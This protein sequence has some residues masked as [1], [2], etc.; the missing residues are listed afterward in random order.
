MKIISTLSNLRVT[1][2]CVVT[3]VAAPSFASW[4]T[5]SAQQ[6]GGSRAL[7]RRGLTVDGRIE[8]AVQQL[9]S[10]DATI[11]DGAAITG[12]LLAPGIPAVRQ[13]QSANLGSITQGSG[14]EQ[15]D[16]YFVTLS[17]N[18]QLG[19][20]KRRTDPVTIPI[21]AAPPGAN[22]S[23]DVT[24]SESDHDAG[25]FATIRDLTITGGGVIA[26]PPGTYRDL[27]ATGGGGFVLGTAG[28]TQPA[29]YNI[30]SLALNE[31]GQLQIVGPV[32]LTMAASVNL[33][34]S[35]GASGNPHWLSL[36]VASGDVTL[37]GGGSLFGLVTAPTATVTINGNSSLIGNVVCDRLVVNAGGLLRIVD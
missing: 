34:G 36:K 25:D 7:V 1:I 28:A 30:S 19:E 16:G 9:N 32:I 14:S 24:L 20:L 10:E 3:V 29:I 22:G 5:T 12:I 37:N 35:M 17:G 31:G 21:V 6:Q 2:L 4:L 23:R 26:V 33:S 15:P 11:N 8:G 13:D 27:V 18:A